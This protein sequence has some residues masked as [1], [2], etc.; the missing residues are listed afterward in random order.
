MAQTGK[1][2]NRTGKSSGKASAARKPAAPKK[3]ADQRA[4]REAERHAPVSLESGASYDRSALEKGLDRAMDRQDENRDAEVRKALDGARAGG[5]TA[6]NAPNA[7][8]DHQVM[9]TETMLAEGVE[10]GEG[11]NKQVLG[12]ETV[13]EF[14]QVYVG[15]GEAR[16]ASDVVGSVQASGGQSEIVSMEP[17]GDK[18]KKADPKPPVT[19]TP[20]VPATDNESGEPGT[21]SNPEAVHSQIEGASGAGEDT[22]TGA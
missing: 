1:N 4:A 10:V 19:D 18:P 9:R 6:G 8:P 11:K 3:T 14:R 16:Q 22:N 15:D 5:P 12:R 2:A 20:D 21:T 13:T 7:L 17:V